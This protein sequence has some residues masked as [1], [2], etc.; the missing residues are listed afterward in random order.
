M[1]SRGSIQG[2]TY[3]NNVADA[4]N[5]IDIAVGAA[6]DGTN[7]R[8]M[9]LA[10]ALT[11]KLDAA[12]AVGTNQ[13]GLDTGAIADTDYFIW[14]IERSDTGVVDVGF[15]V[16]ASSPTMP[17]NYDRK[18]YIGA[19]IRSGA[20]IRP[21]TQV[22][23]LFLYTTEV[24]VESGTTCVFTFDANP[25]EPGGGSWEKSECR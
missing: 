25:N 3:S 21:F 13:G 14:Q 16:S 6:M 11:K 2:L 1:V 15:D 19:I 22:G 12:W 8:M 7:T 10:A 4:T 18:R 5:D 20:T 24:S 23:N 9:V 17:T